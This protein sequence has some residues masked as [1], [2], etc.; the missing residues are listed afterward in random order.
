MTT[1]NAVRVWLNGEP[2]GTYKI[3]HGGSQP[4]QYAMEAKLKAGP[5]L[6]LVKLC[7]NEITPEWARV[8]NFRLRVVDR[9]GVAVNSA[10]PKR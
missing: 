10:E 2:V 4:D 3:Y 1:D 6:I 8:W 7:Q 9:T 5:N